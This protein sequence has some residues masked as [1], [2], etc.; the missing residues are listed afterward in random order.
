[1]SNEIT[2]KK[3]LFAGKMGLVNSSALV[4]ALAASAQKDPRGGG[5]N[6]G[7]FVN[8]SGKHGTYQVGKDKSEMD[9]EELWLIN[10]ASFEDG[11]ICWK[12]G[13]VQALRLYPMGVPVP[14][15]D[16]EEHG[17]FQK[18][19]DGWKQ[20]KSLTM[21]SLDSLMQ[22]YFKVNAVSAVSVF[23]DLQDDILARVRA[24]QPAWPV[25]K[26]GKEKFL[27]KGDWN[28][29]PVV[30]IDGWLD[31]ES[32]GMLAELLEDEAAEFDIGELYEAS[33]GAGAPVAVDKQIA[34]KPSPSVGETVAAKV[35]TSSADPAADGVAVRRRRVSL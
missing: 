13:A 30:T 6:G 16:F 27:A 35:A 23:A 10:I 15:P 22:G 31:D 29:K 11:W 28:F 12:G 33:A 25:V 8:F 24:G 7:E 2:E 3:P 26:W 1:M 5:A 20:A 17:P 18:Q 4:D 21:K 34:A 14:E 9:P 19:G 32:V